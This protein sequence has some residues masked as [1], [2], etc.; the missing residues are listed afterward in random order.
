VLINWAHG[1]KFDFFRPY[2]SHIQKV[3]GIK[4]YL[5]KLPAE[6]DDDLVLIIDGFDVWMQLR[7]EVM[8]ERYY[9][10]NQAA[11]ERIIRTYGKDQAQKY[12]MRQTVVWGADKKCFPQKPNAPACYAV[13]NSTLAAD[14]YGPKT[15]DKSLSEDITK[16]TWIARRPRWLNSGTVM[17]PVK[18]LRPIFEA[19]YAKYK[20]HNDGD[21]DQFYF[22]ELFGE[23]EWYRL[24][25]TS[26]D[27]S[28]TSLQARITEP[29]LKN[30][31][32]KDVPSDAQTEL[33]M[34]L[35]YENQLFHTNTF[36]KD[37]NDWIVYNGTTDIAAMLETH[38][39]DGTF[40]ADLPQDILNSRL[41]FTMPDSFNT[42]DKPVITWRDVPLATN[43]R[44]RSVPA[45]VHINGDKVFLFHW[46]RNMWFQPYAKFLMDKVVQQQE[47]M[48]VPVAVYN[49]ESSGHF[50][51]VPDVDGWWKSPNEAASFFTSASQRLGWDRICKAHDAM[52][53]A[54]GS[55]PW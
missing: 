8:I 23:Q 54:K 55:T 1:P 7:P 35:D 49:R 31:N 22:G 39:I 41:P 16:V 25:R 9:A 47:H 14:I 27:M 19:A 15:D 24:N 2:A 50:V 44:S 3:S 4:D 52:V 46:W 37:D 21:R 48:Q 11:N 42:T 28:D 17:G 30:E 36:S 6:N 32:P 29:I 38:K 40:S 5:N 12:D 53:L 51:K 43:L 20:R 33:H 18:E 13:P 10:I 45:I 34:G 26:T